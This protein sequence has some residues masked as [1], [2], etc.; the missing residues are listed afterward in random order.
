MEENTKDDNRIKTEFGVLP[1][2]EYYE[3]QWTTD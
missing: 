1:G 2:I 3:F